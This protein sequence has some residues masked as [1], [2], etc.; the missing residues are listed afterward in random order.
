MEI[1]VEFFILFE[2][3]S[4]NQTTLDRDHQLTSKSLDPTN[5]VFKDV[6]I[7][8]QGVNLSQSIECDKNRLYLLNLVEKLSQTAQNL[9]F[10]EYTN[11]QIFRF[12]KELNDN[13]F[14]TLQKILP[15]LKTLTFKLPIFESDLV[16]I[17]HTHGYSPLLNHSF[18]NHQGFNDNNIYKLYYSFTKNSVIFGTKYRIEEEQQHMLNSLRLPSIEDQYASQLSL[19]GG[20]SGA[21]GAELPG[22]GGLPA[23]PAV[24]QPSGQQQHQRQHNQQHYTEM[25]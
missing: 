12:A 19:A 24:P 2:L 21:Q 20:Y 25:Q 4:L 8:R 23:K 22:T 5:L 18:N 15:R 3:E 7:T 13:Q 6:K 11:V 1:N 14:Q 10:T 17:S 16:L 9:P